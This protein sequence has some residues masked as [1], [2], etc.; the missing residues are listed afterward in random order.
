MMTDQF[1]AVF[2]KPPRLLSCDCE[3]SNETTLGQTFHLISGPQISKL[4]GDAGNR[5]TKLIAAGKNDGEIVEELYW[6]ALT[7][8]PTPSE[9]EAMVGHI[10]AAKDRRKGIENVLWAL[11]NAKEFVLRK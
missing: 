5:V 9:R 1:L 11:L 2:G 4:V 6:A 3:R 10:A 8:G 7:R